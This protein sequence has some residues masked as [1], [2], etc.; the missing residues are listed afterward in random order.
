MSKAPTC[1]SCGEGIL[2]RVTVDNRRIPLDRFA[3][4]QGVVAMIDGQRCRIL[5]KADAEKARAEGAVLWMPHHATC[6][7]ASRHRVGRDQMAL[8]L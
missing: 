4:A 6:P 2:W 5:S 1:Q 8:E 3:D 7:T